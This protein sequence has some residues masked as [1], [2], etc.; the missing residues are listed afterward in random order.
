M[1]KFL[2]YHDSDSS[3]SYSQKII[4]NT[5]RSSY[6]ILFDTGAGIPVW[7]SDIKLLFLEYPDAKKSNMKIPIGGF[8]KGRTLADV[9]LIPDFVLSDGKESLHY[10]NLPI[11]VLKK[12]YSFEMIASFTMFNHLNYSYSYIGLK[13]PVLTIE[14]PKSKMY[15]ICKCNEIEA[16]KTSIIENVTIF[17]QEEFDGLNS[18]KKH[19][20]VFT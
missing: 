17:T 13:Q 4:Q 2:L 16:E 14:A 8:G 12:D 11:A 20:S 3:N 7:V 9:Y 5:A 18:Y 15:S 19:I 1:L 6:L 10:I